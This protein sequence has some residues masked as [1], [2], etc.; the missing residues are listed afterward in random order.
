MGEFSRGIRMACGGSLPAKKGRKGGGRGKS[1]KKKKKKRKAKRNQNAWNRT[2][3][4]ASSVSGPSCKHLEFLSLAVCLSPERGCQRM[5]GNW[6]ARRELLGIFSD[7]CNPPRAEVAAHPTPC[8]D[9]PAGRR[10]RP[11]PPG[12]PAI[13]VPARSGEAAPGGSGSGS[14]S[15]SRRGS[16]ARSPARLALSLSSFLFSSNAHGGPRRSAAESLAASHHMPV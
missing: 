7:Q 10:G 16:L 14:G 9:A 15:G 12:G 5:S 2:H 13:A 1:K 6:G 3:E 11:F 8:G 4:K